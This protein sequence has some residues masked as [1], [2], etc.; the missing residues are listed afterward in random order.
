MKHWWEPSKKT[1]EK[2]MKRILMNNENT[3]RSRQVWS[4]KWMMRE[5]LFPLG[6][7]LH[8]R[9]F[10]WLP[11]ESCVKVF[12]S[13]KGR[14]SSFTDAILSKCPPGPSHSYSIPLH[15]KQFYFPDVKYSARDIHVIYLSEGRVHVQ[16]VNIARVTC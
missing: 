7:V 9:H 4:W 16:D 14:V 12:Q 5:A 1:E 10:I 6:V 11:N 2:E 3:G 15:L 8:S 13:H